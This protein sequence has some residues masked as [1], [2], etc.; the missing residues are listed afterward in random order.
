V[1]QRKLQ[2]ARCRE[3]QT[4]DRLHCHRNVGNVLFYT[5]RRYK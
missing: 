3:R 2:N 5:E 1:A 4:A